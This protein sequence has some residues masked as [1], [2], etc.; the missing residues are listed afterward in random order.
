MMSLGDWFMIAGTGLYVCA[1]VAYY[2]QGMFPFAVT[3]VFYAGANV[4]LIWSAHWRK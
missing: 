1:A 4:G 2:V 3:Y